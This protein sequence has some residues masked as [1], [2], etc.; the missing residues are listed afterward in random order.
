M[1]CTRYLSCNYLCIHRSLFCLF[2]CKLIQ[3]LSFKRITQLGFLV[4]ITLSGLEVILLFFFDLEV[5]HSWRRNSESLFFSAL[6]IAVI[7][8]DNT[9]AEEN[10][11]LVTATGRRD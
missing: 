6:L 9:L 10:C 3:L 5:I 4:A 8:A 11:K 1:Y 7:L 2:N